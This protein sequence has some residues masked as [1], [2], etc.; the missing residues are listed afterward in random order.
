MSRIPVALAVA[1]A[2]A[3]PVGAGVEVTVAGDRLDVHAARAPLSEVLDGLAGKTRMK[4]VYEGAA[5]RTLVSVSLTGRT[6]AE[7]V[8]GVLEGLGLD[9][10]LIL[11]GA[12]TEVETLMIV[13][14]GG[15]SAPHAASSGRAQPPAAPDDPG[16][17]DAQP[18]DVE[19]ARSKAEP[20]EVPPDPPTPAAPPQFGPVN[21][22][23]RSY[24]TSPFAPGPPKALPPPPT[25]APS[26]A[27][28][29]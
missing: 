20:H 25:P 2:L 13:G 19:V 29:R 6:P 14:Q 26:P 11:N 12:G 22:P 23:A 9:Y 1:L 7:A 28:N 8:L 15:P 4:V 5:P 27:S 3:A 16:F 24:P 18:E 10:A 21:P 17:D